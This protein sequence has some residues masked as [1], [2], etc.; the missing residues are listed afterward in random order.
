M[1]LMNEA[2]DSSCETVI[3]DGQEECPQA[4]ADKRRVNAHSTAKL[5][6]VLPVYLLGIDQKC[7][8]NGQELAIMSASH[9]GQDVHVK[10][11]KNLMGKLGI[12]EDQM[13]IP[14]A[15]PAGKLAR[16]Y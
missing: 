6:Q 11:L 5:I 2:Y 14:E 13:C 4:E 10:V 8:L 12:Q 9:L 16:R 1:K 3:Y 7:S 15:A